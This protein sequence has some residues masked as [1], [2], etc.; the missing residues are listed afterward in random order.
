[1]LFCYVNFRQNVKK[2]LSLILTTHVHWHF[3]FTPTLLNRYLGSIYCTVH[4]CNPRLLFSSFASNYIR[5]SDPS[6]ILSHTYFC[7]FASIFVSQADSLLFLM[8]TSP[9]R[10]LTFVH[11]AYLLL[12]L[13]ST[14]WFVCF[15]VR[16]SSCFCYFV[17]CLLSYSQCSFIRPIYCFASCLLSGSFA[18]M[19]VCLPVSAIL[20]HAY[21]PIS[22]CLN[23]RSSGRSTIL[24]TTYIPRLPQCT[25][26]CYFVHC[27]LSCS[28]SLMYLCCLGLGYLCSL[29]LTFLFRLLI[30]LFICFSASR[31]LQRDVN[32]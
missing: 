25:F 1:M 24:S 19:D 5:S 17:S 6:A 9:V 18:S 13:M 26:V 21:C 4:S 15:N 2:Y 30:H 8:P 31:G 10:L 20:F 7:S 32:S 11:Q 29:K 27:L 23:A 3:V 22:V 16:L 12:C 28:F 14:F